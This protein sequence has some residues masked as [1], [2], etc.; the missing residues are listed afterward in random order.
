M[1][2]IGPKC[3][4]TDGNKTK[5]KVMRVNWVVF[6]KGSDAIVVKDKDSDCYTRRNLK[7]NANI[8]QKQ[9]SRKSHL[10]RHFM[11]IMRPLFGREG[12]QWHISSWVQRS[13]SSPWTS[14]SHTDLIP[15]QILQDIWAASSRNQLSQDPA[16][17]NPIWPR[18][19]LA[20]Q[21]PKI[22]QTYTPAGVTHR[23]QQ[24]LVCAGENN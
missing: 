15:T 10:F 2:L 19:K 9:T 14:P 16:G 23:T 13:S 5:K 1:N 12:T 22:P 18:A 6:V 3:T 20:V 11:I 21:G 17:S 4:C 8:M 7:S 24:G